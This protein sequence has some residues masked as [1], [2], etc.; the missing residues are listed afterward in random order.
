MMREM[1]LK[2]GLILVAVSGILL[3]AADQPWKDKPV[4][5]WSDGDARQ[6]LSDSPWAKSVAPKI[7]RPSSG[8]RGPRVGVGRGGVGVG[9]GGRGGGMG[10]VPRGGSE[11]SRESSAGAAPNL[12]VRWESA[13][14]V[15]EAQLKIRNA[16]APTVSEDDYT[17]A[18][19]GLP[20]RI[21]GSDPG[22]LESQLK[23]EGELRREGQKSIR[24]TDAR[25]LPRDDGLIILFQFPRSKEITPG[26]KAIE[27]HARIGAFDIDQSYDLADMIY[28]G[29]LQL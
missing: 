25:V 6:I 17:I 2:S 22:V 3:L 16:D 13:L 20:S 7:D 15:Q 27:F 1:V 4:T 11:S 24:S 10:R 5:D 26:D 12:T 28:T 18:V 21:V 9:L 29:R 23:H 14:P 8:Q 19:L